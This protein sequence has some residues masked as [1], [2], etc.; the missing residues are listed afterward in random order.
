MIWVD[1][2]GDEVLVNS[3]AK[4]LKVRNVKRDPRVVLS[5][6]DPSSPQGNLIIR[7]TATVTENG[8]LENID[9]L[10]KRY[11]GLDKYGFHQPGDVR[12]LLRI[13]V[14]DIGGMTGDMGRWE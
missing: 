2:D 13:A 14:D 5:M 8:A 10:A 12:V 7:G 9:R 1:V 11:L 6:Q 3:E 4:R